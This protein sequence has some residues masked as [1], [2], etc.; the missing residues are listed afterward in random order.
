METVNTVL[1]VKSTDESFATLDICKI[2]LNSGECAVYKA[3][4]ATTYIKSADKLLR[5]SLS[6]PP[7]GMGGKLTV[8]AQK[9]TVSAGDKIIMTT[10]GA[11]LDEEW[12]SRELS[13]DT[14][15]K[16]LSEKIARAAR[17]AENGRE[18]DIS[19]IAV[20]VGR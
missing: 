9:F 4:A 5:A 1:M 16:E 8:P 18:D 7:A 17:A 11:V 6:S 19:V 14:P 13:A 3:G 20:T 2:D 12:L 10:D 15:A